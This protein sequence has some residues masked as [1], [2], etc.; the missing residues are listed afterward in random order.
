MGSLLWLLAAPLASAASPGPPEL[1]TVASWSE[2]WGPPSRGVAL[3]ERTRSPDE[4]VLVYWMSVEASPLGVGPA[5]PGTLVANFDAATPV[6]DSALR[7]FTFLAVASPDQ[8]ASLER[9]VQQQGW[10]RARHTRDRAG[11]RF[12]ELSLS[13]PDGRTG[14]VAIRQGPARTAMADGRPSP[15]LWIHLGP[16]T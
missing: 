5:L 2:R 1:P 3:S 9:A 16:S 10:V 8:L 14:T 4:P 7:D 12:E 13:L 6:A 11:G 15:S